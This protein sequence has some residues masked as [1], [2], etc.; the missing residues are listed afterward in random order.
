MSVGGGKG[1]PGKK[2]EER[3]GKEGRQRGKQ[4][5]CRNPPHST[6]CLSDPPRASR[7]S[8]HVLAFPWLSPLLTISLGTE[9]VEDMGT[10]HLSLLVPE[11][12]QDAAT[13]RGPR[14]EQVTGFLKCQHLSACGKEVGSESRMD[15]KAALVCYFL[16]G[17]HTTCPPSGCF[18]LPGLPRAGHPPLPILGHC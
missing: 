7:H 16:G 4:A 17:F 18:P 12:Q 1:R 14:R 8:H 15:M 11:G 6:F 10:M 3:E 5:G 13:T 2:L 9:T